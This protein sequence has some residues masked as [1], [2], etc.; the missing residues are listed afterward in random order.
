MPY[1]TRSPLRPFWANR[2][3]SG[4]AAGLL[5][6]HIRGMPFL[7]C[8]LPNLLPETMPPDPEL[9]DL[10][11][12]AFLEGQIDSQMADLACLWIQAKQVICPA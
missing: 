4:N 9:V 3:D 2:Q 10:I 7:H 1:S 12:W 5:P 11:E 8:E 6:R